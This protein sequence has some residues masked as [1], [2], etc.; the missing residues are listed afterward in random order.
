MDTENQYIELLQKVKSQI[1]G[2]SSNY[3]KLVTLIEN[4]QMVDFLLNISTF[5]KISFH[6]NKQHLEILPEISIDK[7]SLV[8]PESFDV[9]IPIRLSGYYLIKYPNS[10]YEIP[11]QIPLFRIEYCCIMVS[12]NN[13]YL[14]KNEH[15]RLLEE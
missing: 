9:R 14:F 1:I 11:K 10:Q 5:E 8:Y 2:E 6:I 3:K 13:N 15:I 12:D 7:L 4:T